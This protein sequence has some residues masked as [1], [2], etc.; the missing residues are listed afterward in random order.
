MHVYLDDENLHY[1]LHPLMHLSMS[2]QIIRQPLL[3]HGTDPHLASS[4]ANICTSTQESTKHLWSH[5]SAFNHHRT[6]ILTSTQPD[7]HRQLIYLAAL[8]FTILARVHAQFHLTRPQVIFSQSSAVLKAPPS[9][10]A[11]QKKKRKRNAAV[12]RV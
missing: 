2:V 5:A 7:P 1:H 9:G 6:G 10:T 8:A 12:Q 4:F 3:T 11:D